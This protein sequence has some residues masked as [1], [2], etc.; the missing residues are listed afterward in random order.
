MLDIKRASTWRYNK[1]PKGVTRCR[2][3][4]VNDLSVEGNTHSA[5]EE[6]GILVGSGTSVESDVTTGD[7][8]GGVPA[9]AKLAMTN[10]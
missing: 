2:T 8:L 5:Q 1:K 6:T 4:L 3:T 9:S 7:H 10:Q